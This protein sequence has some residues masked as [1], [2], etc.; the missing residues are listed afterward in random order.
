MSSTFEYNA[1][2]KHIKIE[3][4]ANFICG[5]R[6]DGYNGICKKDNY[7]SN[8][9]KCVNIPLN[10]KLPIVGAVAVS[11]QRNYGYRQCVSKFDIHCVNTKCKTNC[12]NSSMKIQ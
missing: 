5:D 12:D 6:K 4:G 3:D 1:S 11:T 10:S 2:E 9:N 7:C 8:D